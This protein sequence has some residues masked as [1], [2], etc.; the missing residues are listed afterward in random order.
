MT[1]EHL[2]CWE[3]RDAPGAGVGG[4]QQGA[5]PRDRAGIALTSTLG[6]WSDPNEMENHLQLTPDTNCGKILGWQFKEWKGHLESAW[7]A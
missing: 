3:L 1:K 6:I 4:R 2:A 7:R 5:L